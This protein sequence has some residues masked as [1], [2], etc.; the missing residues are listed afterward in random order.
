MAA[1]FKMKLNAML[2]SQYS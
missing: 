2:K 1:A